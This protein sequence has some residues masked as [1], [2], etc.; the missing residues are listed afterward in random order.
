MGFVRAHNQLM[1]FV[2]DLIGFDLL[3]ASTYMQSYSP[4]QW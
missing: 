3:V 4:S 1:I 2:I